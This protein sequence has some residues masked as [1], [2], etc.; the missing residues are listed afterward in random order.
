MDAYKDE[1]VAFLEN[2]P[3]HFPEA[4]DLAAGDRPRYA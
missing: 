3:E 1:M 2:H 4:L